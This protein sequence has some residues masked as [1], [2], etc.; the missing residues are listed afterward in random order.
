MSSGRQIA[1]LRV[2]LAKKPP[3]QALTRKQIAHEVTHVAHLNLSRFDC[4]V[5]NRVLQCCGKQVVDL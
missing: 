5:L 2:H 4:R 1:E 3:D